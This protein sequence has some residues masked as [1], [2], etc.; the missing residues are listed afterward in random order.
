MDQ[1]QHYRGV[2]WNYG[3]KIILFGS[4]YFLTGIFLIITVLHLSFFLFYP[5]QKAN[6]YFSLFALFSM[7]GF[8][9][10]RIVPNDH[11]VEHKFYISNGAFDLMAIGRL[12]M[13]VALYY[14][15]E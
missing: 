14:L 8:L 10:Q 12:L 15:L 4:N 2:N 3:E 1:C 7:L 5:S 9:L 13:V 6:L 11:W